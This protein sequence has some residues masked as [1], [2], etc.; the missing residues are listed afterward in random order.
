MKTQSQTPDSSMSQMD[1][2]VATV[3]QPEIM[4]AKYGADIPSAVR[5]I[6]KESRE[7]FVPWMVKAGIPP[8][9][10][11]ALIEANRAAGELTNLELTGIQLEGPLVTEAD[12]VDN[13]ADNASLKKMRA[14]KDRHYQAGMRKKSESNTKLADTLVQEELKKARETG[15]VPES[16]KTTRRQA[17][18]ESWLKRMVNKLLGKDGDKKGNGDKR[19]A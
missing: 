4:E 2:T 5:K 14:I 10:A 8:W 6:I 9:R 11:V 18:G 12:L 19:A 7:E 17:N 13:L 16:E 1:R 15:S 3:Q